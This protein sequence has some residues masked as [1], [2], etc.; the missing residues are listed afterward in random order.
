M[1]FSQSVRKGQIPIN[2]GLC[3]TDRPIKW[4]CLDCD[5][6]L[7]NHCKEKVH[8]RVK[9]AK[10]H[11]IIDIKEIGLHK[12]ELDFAN[13]PCQD[14][15]GQYT[16]LY[17]KTCDTLVCPTCVAKV[18][19]KHDLTEIQEGYDIKIDKLKKGQSKIQKN[20]KEIVLRKEQISKL[21]LAESTKYNQ[22]TQYINEHEHSVKATVER[23]FKKLRDELDQNQS[24][25]SNTIKSDLN[26]VSVILKEADDKNNKVQE[27]IQISN[28]SKFFTEASNLEK[29]VDMQMPKLR[30]S[31]GSIPNFIPRE[32]TQSNIG[33]LEYEE[34]PSHQPHI[35][36]EKNK[37]YQTV[38]EVIK[39]VC[40]STDQSLWISSGTLGSV[41]KVKPDG[42][43]LKVLSS[44][45]IKVYGMAVTQSNNLL[46]CTEGSRLQEISSNMGKLTDTVYN[47][48]PFLPGAVHITSDNKVLVGCVNKDFPK[49]GRR[50]VIIMNK[51]G[52][53]ERVYEQDEYKKPIFTIPSSINTTG[54]GNIHVV[55]SV[56]SDMGRVVVLG[57]GGDI[58]N[59][60]TGDTDINKDIPFQPTGIVTTPRDNVIVADL[61][62]CTLHILNNVGLLMTYYKTSDINIIYPLSLAFSQTGQLYIGCSKPK[63]SKSKDATMYEVTIS[64]C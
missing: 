44:Y 32:I 59:I 10:D 8:L 52:G 1:A 64:G 63:G 17:C 56:S 6:L 48:Y 34:N 62:T 51:K 23:Y 33:V 61:D 27:F 12:E 30:S 42:T 5:L 26:A 11:R 28:A 15:T 13:I 41:Q 36:L 24:T 25:V 37:Q 4:K 16:C 14:H 19:K 3:E 46:L 54:N 18:H 21:L 2:C 57:Q 31:Y 47:V 35:N 50:V 20:R 7:C 22:V 55:D 40:L 29:S 43:K 45:D 9:T 38:L 58:I 60:Y 53:Q 39:F 49:Q